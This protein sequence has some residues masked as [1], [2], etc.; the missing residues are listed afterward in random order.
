M[1]GEYLPGYRANEVEIVRIELM[2]TTADVV[3]VRARSVGQKRVQIE[4]RVVDEYQ[5]DFTFKPHRSS[6]PLTLGQ[7]VDSLDNVKHSAGGGDLSIDDVWMRHGWVLSFIECNRAC[8]DDGDSV[9]HRNFM[10]IS[11]DVYP[12]LVRHY[13]RLIDRWVDAY[14][15]S[16]IGDEEAD[17]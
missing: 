17:E 13:E 11:S 4:Y 15:I 16:E 9:P 12:D 2:S 7:L 3:S 8:S 14:A 5:S 1:G 6:Q 10:T